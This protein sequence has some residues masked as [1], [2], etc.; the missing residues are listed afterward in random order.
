[1]IYGLSLVS[2]SPLDPS[3]N[4]VNANHPQ[5]LMSTFGSY[6][7]DLAYQMVGFGCYI[8]FFMGLGWAWRFLTSTPIRRVG[9]RLVS[10]IVTIA[11]SAVLFGLIEAL[12]PAIAFHRPLELVNLGG[13]IGYGMTWLVWNGFAL[14][15][16]LV[17]QFQLFNVIRLEH[18]VLAILILLVLAI[19][20][21]CL[22]FAMGLRKH[23]WQAMGRLLIRMLASLYAIIRFKIP[24]FRQSTKQ[25]RNIYANPAHEN[26]QQADEL[27]KPDIAEDFK[28]LL[29]EVK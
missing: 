23:E 25:W 19:G 13:M 9:L 15:Q 26:E 29:G 2:Y 14:L 21:I 28:T 16:G 17:P 20:F 5:N 12:F 6:S 27:D 22:L 8:P 1:M 10:G 4:V 18:L 11:L 7:A 24:E 3:F